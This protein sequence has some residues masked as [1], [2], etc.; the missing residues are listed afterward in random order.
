MDP[1]GN[2][3]PGN[4]RIMLQVWSYSNMRLRQDGDVRSLM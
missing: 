2:K 4:A 1:L 3:N